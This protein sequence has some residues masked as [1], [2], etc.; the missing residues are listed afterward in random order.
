MEKKSSTHN[1]AIFIKRY[2]AASKQ[3]QENKGMHPCVCV[4]LPPFCSLSCLN[5]NYMNKHMLFQS[6]KQYRDP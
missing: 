3:N 4:V 1:N 2:E 5:L 6:H